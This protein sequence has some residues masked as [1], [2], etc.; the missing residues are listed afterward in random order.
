MDKRIW[1][2]SAAV[3]LFAS[4]QIGV[5]SANLIFDNDV[6]AKGT[7]FGTQANILT[8]HD[9]G[10][11]GLA[12]DV[13]DGTVA[14][15]GTDQT[16]TG[17]DVVCTPIGKTSLYTF[18]QLD[19]DSAE[20]VILI[21]NPDEV[22]TSVQ[23]NVDELVLTIYNP[24]GTTFFTASLASPVSFTTINHNGV[25]GEGFGFRLDSTEAAELNTA[26]GLIPTTDR[27]KLI[28]G[29]HSSVSF[30]DNGPDTW[31]I[32]N[33]CPVGETCGAPP[34]PCTVDC[35]PQQIPEPSP[36]FL[37]AVALLG[38]AM[39]RRISARRSR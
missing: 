34:E 20:Q 39:T 24:D 6:D 5:A 35:N 22:G 36:L 28:I 37:I 19:L 7:G 4:F 32:Q 12:T 21:W 1:W 29:L 30:V 3:G 9:T 26:L 23:T 31:T 27:D 8:L 2:F 18:G 11:A 17:N 13:E 14:W 16:C 25:G 33:L 10:G 15:S 38:V